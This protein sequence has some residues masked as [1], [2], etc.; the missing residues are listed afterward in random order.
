MA[1]IDEEAEGVRG[2]WISD[3]HTERLRS[4]VSQYVEQTKRNVI[5][6]SS[7]STDPNVMRAYIKFIEATDRL[8]IF[9]SGQFLKRS[10][11]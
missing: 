3:P 2:A 8:R 9:G 11:T 4:E 6:V 10:K 5:A 7:K 1:D